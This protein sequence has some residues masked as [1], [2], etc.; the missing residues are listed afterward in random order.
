[1]FKYR[2]CTNFLVDPDDQSSCANRDKTQ[3]CLR[4]G[5]PSF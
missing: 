1:L 5:T 3:I 2:P 4:K